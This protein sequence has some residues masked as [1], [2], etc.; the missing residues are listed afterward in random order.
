MYYK[1]QVLVAASLH[2]DSLFG[3]KCLDG[4]SNSFI[5]DAV[6]DIKNFS[7]WGNTIVFGKM[8]DTVAENVIFFDNLDK[9][10]TIFESLNS[11]NRRTSRQEVFRNRFIRPGLKGFRQFA[12]KGG[13]MI[14][15][16]WSIEVLCRWKLSDL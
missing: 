9:I 6:Q 15:E 8:K 3:R 1:S 14:I 13:D 4:H 11:V 10:K 12:D 5:E 2:F 7:A 16:C